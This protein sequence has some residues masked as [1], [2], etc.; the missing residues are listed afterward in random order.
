[1]EN[2]FDKIENLQEQD[3]YVIDIFHKNIDGHRFFELEK[4]YLKNYINE[5]AKK[6]CKIVMQI[7]SKYEVEIYLTEFPD[8]TS[9]EY[10]ELAYQNIADK[11][12]SQLYEIVEY[13]ILNNI[14]SVQILIPE[15]N[16]LFSVD[17]EFQVI[18][19]NVVDKHMEFIREIVEKEGLYFYQP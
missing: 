4:V 17:G 7:I 19:Y 16:F 13:V 3:Y 2:V 12:L 11:K 6:I 18:V 15:Y 1:M 8:G 10:A 14:S 9:D 5:F